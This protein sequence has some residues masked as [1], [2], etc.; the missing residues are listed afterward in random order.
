MAAGSC[1]YQRHSINPEKIFC[2]PLQPKKEN[3]VLFSIAVVPERHEIGW[4]MF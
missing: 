1:R 2:P 4:V 3:D